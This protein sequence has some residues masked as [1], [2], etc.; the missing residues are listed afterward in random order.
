MVTR[1][2]I[3]C[4][5]AGGLSGILMVVGHIYP[6]LA[7]LQAVALLPIFYFGLK[8]QIRTRVI[9]VSGMYMGLGYTLP[10]I[11]V[12]CLPV[13]M[14][15]I[16]VIYLTAV[17]ML[18]V[19]ISS[20]LLRGSPIW[21]SFAVGAFLV[22]LDWVN[23]TALPFWGAAQSLVRAWSWYPDLI[24][25]VSITGITGIIFVIG[26]LQALA[27]NCLV[28]PEL[29]L[30]LIKA[31]IVMI[32][33]FLVFN[34][35]ALFQRPT[36]KL[37]VA[38]VGWLNSGS[39]DDDP[40]TPEGFDKLFIQPVAQ[41]AKQGAR[42][43]VSG[44]MGFYF[45]KY[46]RE[47]WLNRFRHIAHEHNV[48]LVIGYLNAEKNENRL[49]FM[50][51]EGKILS[52]YTKTYQTFIEETN[53]G[54]GQLQVIDIEGIKVGGMICH[55]DNYTCLTREYGKRSVGIVAIPTLDWLTVKNAHLQSSIS[56]AIE[57]RYVIVRAAVNGISVIISP[58]GKVL[59]RRDHFI[60]G[61]G[62]VIAEV[63]V[64]VQRTLFSIAG[65]WPVG[66]SVVFL[67]IY[68]GRNLKLTCLF[69][70]Q[71]NK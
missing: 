10:Q 22:V 34:A 44:E 4:R 16:L 17:M 15:V 42:L 18:L 14:T 46:D 25:F 3:F 51:P 30:K 64:Y 50:N 43:I 70:S 39:I 63:P 13:P 53:N 56:R 47:K 45:D 71:R 54:D 52:E 58:M 48:F 67:A 20:R 1:N 26:T 6:V 24:L 60:E 38:A 55:D 62:V 66:L 32:F 57:S 33:V 23:F 31:G 65:H 29:R 49:F 9:L 68:I 69:S 59:A 7:G 41:A 19:W 11:V 36:G 8:G 37:K 2:E 27:V 28:H 40:Q 61:P 5:I 12:L 21:G 35:V